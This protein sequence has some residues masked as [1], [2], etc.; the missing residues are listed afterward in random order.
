M[1]FSKQKCSHE[2]WLLFFIVP[3]VLLPL[4][5]PVIHDS[6]TCLTLS[7]CHPGAHSK[8]LQLTLEDEIKDSALPIGME[9]NSVRNKVIAALASSNASTSSNSRICVW[10]GSSQGVVWQPESETQNKTSLSIKV[11]LQGSMKRRHPLRVTDGFMEERRL[12]EKVMFQSLS[13]RKGKAAFS[14]EHFSSASS[15]NSNSNNNTHT[16]ACA[17]EHHTFS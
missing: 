10:L 9:R 7:L 6:K 11:G 4:S 8:I 17:H 5:L 12:Q 13:P 14:Q 15:E 1:P 16:H 2:C 3:S